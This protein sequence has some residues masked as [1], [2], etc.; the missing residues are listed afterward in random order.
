MHNK[1]HTEEA[2]Q[3]MRDARLRN[4]TRYWANKELPAHVRD[5]Q[6]KS[7]IGNSFAKGKTHKNSD[8][9]KEKTR[10]RMLGDK[11]PRWVKDRSKLQR[12]SDASKDRRSSAYNEWRKRVL[13]RDNFTCKIA[14]PE[15]IGR[16]EA[17]HILGWTQYPELRYEIN[18]GITLCHF[19][20]PRKRVDEKRL[21]PYFQELVNTKLF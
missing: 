1:P 21:S 12:Y 15:C 6:L 18:N 14:N 5:A 8:S 10:L 13:L 11:N 7:V 3:K 2:K 19:H 20:H 16:I 17:H 9:F 4:P